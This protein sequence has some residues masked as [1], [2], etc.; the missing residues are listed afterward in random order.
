MN[1]ENNR[2]KSKDGRGHA[3][4]NNIFFDRWAQL[5]DLEKYL[6]RPLRRKSSRFLGIAPPAKIL[7]VATGTGA[8]AYEMARLGHD[9]TGIDIS[10][11]MLA[12]ARKKLS[13][14]LKL[15]FQEADGTNLPYMD[16]SFDVATI[17]WGIHDMPYEIGLQVLEE[18]KRVTKKKGKIMIVDYMEPKKHPVAK[19][20]HPLICL[21][22]T[23]NYR[24]FIRRGINNYVK[25][26]G[27]VITKEG[28][29]MGIWQMLVLEK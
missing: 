23:K 14:N 16:N 6:F 29:Y 27:L 26:V 7:D 5:Y 15:K 24:P 10:P 1:R 19:F 4:D 18:M 13:P 8:L 28:N 9:V 2:M 11:G 20:T 21:Y 3:E 25:N 12:Q 22:E 17:S